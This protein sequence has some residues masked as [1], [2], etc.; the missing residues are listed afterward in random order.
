MDTDGIKSHHAHVFA[1]RFVLNH[2]VGR[3]FL[4]SLCQQ[5]FVEFISKRGRVSFFTPAAVIALQHYQ[6]QA[7]RA[8]VQRYHFPDGE[9]EQI[10]GLAV[11]RVTC[12]I[13]NYGLQRG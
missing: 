1:A 6:R 9:T 5:C 13:A 4:P 7:A 10:S 3:R 11:L 8:P 12:S 2:Y